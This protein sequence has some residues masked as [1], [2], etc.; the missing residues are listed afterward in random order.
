MV[1]VKDKVTVLYC[2][3]VKKRLVWLYLGLCLCLCVRELIYMLVW[4]SV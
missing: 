2:V 1:G 3:T 4:V